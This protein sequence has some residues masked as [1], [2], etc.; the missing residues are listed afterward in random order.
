MHRSAKVWSRF[1]VTMRHER[2]VRS[3]PAN[4]LR[5]KGLE[6]VWKLSNKLFEL[7]TTCKRD[8]LTVSK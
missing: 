3:L 1:S 5:R 2:A 8:V 6:G 4:A 7:P